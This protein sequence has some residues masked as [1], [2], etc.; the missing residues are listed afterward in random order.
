MRT[1]DTQYILE[2]AAKKYHY[3]IFR[4]STEVPSLV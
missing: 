2:A 3:E 1:Y 4:V